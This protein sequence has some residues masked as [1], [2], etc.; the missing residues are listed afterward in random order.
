M[1][2]ADPEGDSLSLGAE[3]TPKWDDTDE[4]RAESDMIV[5]SC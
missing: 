5:K 2:D 1:R 4:D 3:M